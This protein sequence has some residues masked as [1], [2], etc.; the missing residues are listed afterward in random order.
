MF[1]SRFFSRLRLAKL[2]IKIPMW[3]TFYIKPGE[4]GILYNRSDFKKI[5]TSGTYT[6]FGRL[7]DIKVERSLYYLQLVASCFGRVLM[8]KL[9]ILVMMRN[10]HL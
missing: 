8:S 5:L 7:L 1:L 2:S 4:I 10:C 6:Y 3:K 9:S